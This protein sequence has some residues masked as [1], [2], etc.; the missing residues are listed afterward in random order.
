MD[1]MPGDTVAILPN[2]LRVV[3]AGQLKLNLE[4]FSDVLPYL[5][6]SG[7]NNSLVPFID[8]ATLIFFLIALSIRLAV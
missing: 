5:G 4:T 2:F 8:P 1:P 6:P 7:H 3:R